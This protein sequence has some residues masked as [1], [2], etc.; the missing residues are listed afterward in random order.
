VIETEIVLQGQEQ[1]VLG[2]VEGLTGTLCVLVFD[3]LLCIGHQTGDDHANASGAVCERVT[4]VEYEVIDVTA[5][6]VE[7][8]IHKN[9]P[10]FDGV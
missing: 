6:H 10:E 2:T 3:L 7:T 4:N 9:S 8:V 1:Q 5:V